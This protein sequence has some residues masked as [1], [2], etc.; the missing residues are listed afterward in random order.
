MGLLTKMYP[1]DEL[2]QFLYS[3]G[4]NLLYAAVSVVLG[5]LILVVIHQNQI[6]VEQS[7]LYRIIVKN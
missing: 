5:R 4:Y 6:S 3:E 2:N 7:P 1:F